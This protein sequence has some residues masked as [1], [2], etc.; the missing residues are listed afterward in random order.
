MRLH[1]ALSLWVLLYGRSDSKILELELSENEWLQVKYL[2]AVLFPFFVWTEVLSKSSSITVNIAWMIY[3]GLLAHLEKFNALFHESDCHWKVYLGNCIALA[4]SKL[5]QYYAKTDGDKGLVY[6][7]ACV[8]D[9]SKRLQLYI[10]LDFEAKYAGIDEAEVQKYYGEHYAGY[11][12]Q[13]PTDAPSNITIDSDIINLVYAQQHVGLSITKGTT[14]IDNY[15]QA[16]PTADTNVLKFWKLHKRQYPGLAQM[17]KDILSV[18]L[19]CVSVERIFS[20]ARQIVTYQQNCLDA[21][22]IQQLTIVRH[23]TKLYAPDQHHGNKRLLRQKQ[24]MGYGKADFNFAR[25]LKL[26][27]GD[28]AGGNCG[29]NEF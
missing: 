24:K 25:D 5:S 23:H 11:K 17:A 15:L 7:L 19:A 20:I 3:N 9:L 2:V 16:L 14:N 1:E 4:H 29:Q 10:S 8:L 6:N 18:L 21:N 13:H 28:D 26:S 12:N 27:D 22:T